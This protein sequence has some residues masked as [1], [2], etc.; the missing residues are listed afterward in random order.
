MRYSE[1]LPRARLCRKAA[2]INEEEQD[3][4]GQRRTQVTLPKHNGERDLAKM[5]YDEHLTWFDFTN[6]L[7]KHIKFIFLGV[8]QCSARVVCFLLV[9]VFFNMWCVVQVSGSSFDLLHR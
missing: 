3:L 4:K 8:S 1:G 6:I 7:F 5:V 2:S 9:V